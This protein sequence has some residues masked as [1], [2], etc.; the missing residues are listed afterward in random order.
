MRLPSKIGMLLLS[1]WLGLAA[2]VPA[3]SGLGVLLSVLAIVAGVF[4]F[5]DR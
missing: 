1:I 2:F 5:L 4:I 3:I